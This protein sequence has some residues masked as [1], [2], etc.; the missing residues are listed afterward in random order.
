MRGHGAVQAQRFR[1][2]ACEM[3]CAL[4][5]IDARRIDRLHLARCE[6]LTE[7][8]RLRKRVSEL[9]AIAP[10]EMLQDRQV[11]ARC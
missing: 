9:D 4:K 7:L 8:R 5:G 3:A 1:V 10:D 6:A 11:I 2:A